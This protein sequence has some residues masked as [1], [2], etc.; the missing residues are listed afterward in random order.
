MSNENQ[1]RP[2]RYKTILP[3]NLFWGK[4]CKHHASA[5]DGTC[6]RKAYG[7]HKQCMLC[8]RK[9]PYDTNQLEFYNLVTTPPTEEE[10]AER[11]SLGSTAASVRWNK[12]NKDKVSLYI[13]KYRN[14]PER[15]KLLAER[16]QERYHS[17]TE[18]EK[19]QRSEKSRAYYLKLKEKRSKE[20]DH[21]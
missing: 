20:V 16:F 6:L 19:Q 2:R 4:P 8:S 9:L 21:D 12:K 10:L 5:P 14:K 18:E 15:K 3:E 11:K 7:R 1:T 17:M 13:T